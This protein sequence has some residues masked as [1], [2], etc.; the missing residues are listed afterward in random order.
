MKSIIIYSTKYGSV[1]KAAEMLA[2]KMGSEVDLINVMEEKV[3][4]L[5]EYENVIIG[6]SIYI[7]KIQK[8]LSNYINK[9]LSVLSTRRV[10]LFI[11]GGQPEPDRTKQLENVFPSGLYNHAVV[12]DVFGYEYRID[13]LN[14][15]DKLMLKTIAGIT[16]S[17]YNLSEEKIENFAKIMFES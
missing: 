17:Q 13:K 12:K 6:G 14:F 2:S 5:N 16:E 10:G 3:P 1:K 8:K 9:N 15:L 11:C 4:S 7:G